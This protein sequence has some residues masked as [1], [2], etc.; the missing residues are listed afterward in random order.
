MEKESG[1]MKTSSIEPTADAIEH[2]SA[3]YWAPILGLSERTL[4]DAYRRGELGHTR[5]GD[6]VLI[7]R[8]HIESWLAAN[9]R[10]PRTRGKAA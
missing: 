6:R 1:T 8:K 9:E 3:A 10:Q 2:R 4:R 5:I 7:S